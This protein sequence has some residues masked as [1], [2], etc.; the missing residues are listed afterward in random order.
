MRIFSE[1]SIDYSNNK[2]ILQKIHFFDPL[3]FEWMKSD[4][5]DRCWE[6]C[7]KNERMCKAVSF[8]IPLKQC[9]FFMNS[10]PKKVF[11]PQFVSYTTEIEFSRIL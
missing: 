5:I 6:I 11:D 4:S 3:V 7:E 2:R 9:Q 1:Q 8:Y 10:S